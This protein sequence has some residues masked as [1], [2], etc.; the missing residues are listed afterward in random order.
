MPPPRRLETGNSMASD[1]TS[2]IMAAADWSRRGT[3]PV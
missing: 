3:I 2:P 1:A